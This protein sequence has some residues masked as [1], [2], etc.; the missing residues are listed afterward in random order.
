LTIKKY[1]KLKIHQETTN[2]STASPWQLQNVKMQAWLF[3][4]MTA[5]HL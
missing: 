4:L 3:P 2:L 5:K 1:A